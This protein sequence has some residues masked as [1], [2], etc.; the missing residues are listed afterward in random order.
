MNKRNQLAGEFREVD[1]AVSK[2]IS[3]SAKPILETVVIEVESNR[4]DKY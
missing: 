3:R 2:R 4:L 1:G